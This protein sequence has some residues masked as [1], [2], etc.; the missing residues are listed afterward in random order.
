MGRGATAATGNM[1][2]LHGTANY[3]AADQV[4][5]G[6]AELENKLCAPSPLTLSLSLSMPRPS[7]TQ[8]QSGERRVL[9]FKIL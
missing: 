6:Y 7:I 9:S 1:K 3:V 4:A 5:S 2:L 8:Q